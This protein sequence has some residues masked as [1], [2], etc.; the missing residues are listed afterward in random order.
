MVQK[1]KEFLSPLPVRKLLWVGKKTEERLNALGINTIGELAKHD[2]SILVEK[3]GVI[4]KQLHLM[5]NGID[6]SEVE[7]RTEVKSISKEITFEEDTSDFNLVLNMLDGLSEKV[8][9]EVLIQ[10]FYFRTVTIKLRYENF[11]THTHAKYNLLV[12]WCGGWDL[13]PRRPSPEDLK[14]SPLS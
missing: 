2:P 6:N 8:H 3:F 14:S 10:N 11:E 13:N 5:A 12:N 9:R 4:G 7:E 1:V